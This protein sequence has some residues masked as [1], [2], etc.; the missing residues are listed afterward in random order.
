ML[1]E[2]GI[3]ASSSYFTFYGL[4]IQIKRGIYDFKHAETDGLASIIR[5][6]PKKT[7]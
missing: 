4:T 1:S 7:G 5:Q 3:K 2:Y 6:F